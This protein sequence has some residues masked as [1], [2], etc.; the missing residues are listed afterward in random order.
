MWPDKKEGNLPM[1]PSYFAGYNFTL[2]KQRTPGKE[3]F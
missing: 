2:L 3:R 1:F